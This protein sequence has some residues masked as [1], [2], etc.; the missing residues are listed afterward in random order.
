MD[1][2]NTGKRHPLLSTIC[3]QGLSPTSCLKQVE[4]MEVR[5]ASFARLVRGQCERSGSESNQLCLDRS[6]CCLERD[7]KDYRIHRRYVQRNDPSRQWLGK[8]IDSLYSWH[9]NNSSVPMPM[10]ERFGNATPGVT[11]PEFVPLRIRSP[12]VLAPGFPPRQHGGAPR[13]G[14]MG[15]VSCAK[16]LGIPVLV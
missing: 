8:D 6:R 2:T 10:F 16:W 11:A 5:A 13:H 9:L 15:R 7:N 1:A 3:R 14:T 4:S 12:A